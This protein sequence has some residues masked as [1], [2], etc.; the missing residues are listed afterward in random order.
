VRLPRSAHAAS[1]AA[2]ARCPLYLIAAATVL[3]LGHVP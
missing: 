3:G 2:S 1:G